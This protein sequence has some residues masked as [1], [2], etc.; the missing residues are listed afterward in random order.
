M[1]RRIWPSFHFSH[2]SVPF[3]CFSPPFLLPSSQLFPSF[4][5][6]FSSSCTPFVFLKNLSS[7]ILFA[8]LTRRTLG[9]RWRRRWRRKGSRCWMSRGWGR[10]WGCSR[11]STASTAASWLSWRSELATGNPNITSARAKSCRI[12]WILLFLWL[13]QVC[14]GWM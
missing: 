13:L 7:V 2:S 1:F 11:R 14:G 10:Y 4:L 3:H 9:Q 6:F 12:H 5:L 8:P